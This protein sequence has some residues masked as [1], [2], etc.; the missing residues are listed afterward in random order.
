M[1]SLKKR[2]QAIVK[3][4]ISTNK[5]GILFIGLWHIDSI[6][7]ELKGVVSG[8]GNPETPLGRHLRF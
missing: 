2:D 4:I 5:S 3:N 7:K 8:S 1:K 6:A